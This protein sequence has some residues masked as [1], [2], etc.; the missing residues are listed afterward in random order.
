M[1]SGGDA[2][3]G[4]CNCNG[5]GARECL[6]YLRSGEV[7]DVAGEEPALRRE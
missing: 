6:G 3:R 5:L 7:A 2:G 1:K 4:T